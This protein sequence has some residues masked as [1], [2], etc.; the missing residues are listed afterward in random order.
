MAAMPPVKCYLPD[1]LCTKFG[2][3]AGY[4]ILKVNSGDTVE[5]VIELVLKKLQQR[6]TTH[7]TLRPKFY[8]LAQMNEAQN[9]NVTLADFETMQELASTKSRDGF[10]KLALISTAGHRKTTVVIPNE[11]TMESDAPPPPPLDEEDDAMSMDKFKDLTVETPK[12]PTEQTNTKPAR[13]ASVEQAIEGERTCGMCTRAIP[14]GEYMEIGT[15]AYHVECVACKVC[16]A[17]LTKQGIHLDKV[18]SELLCETHFLDK[19]GDRCA[20]CTEVIIGGVL[21][22]LDGLWHPNCF[23]CAHCLKPLSGG[24]NYFLENE[25][26][27]CRRDYEELFAVRCHHCKLVC[28][29]QYVVMVNTNYKLHPQCLVC[30]TCKQPLDRM[31]FYSD[32][33]SDR[34]YC[35]EHYELNATKCSHCR[36]FINDTVVNYHDGQYHDH[37]FRSLKSGGKELQS[38]KQPSRNAMLDDSEDDEEEDKLE[39]IK[40]AKSRVSAA[41]VKKVV[42]SS[43][44]DLSDHDHDHDDNEDTRKIAASRLPTDKNSFPSATPQRSRSSDGDPPPPPPP[45]SEE[46]NNQEEEEE[47]QEP[48]TPK[49]RDPGS[50]FFSLKADKDI[51]DKTRNSHVS[52]ASAGSE[53]LRKGSFRAGGLLSGLFSSKGGQHKREHSGANLA[54]SGSGWWGSKSGSMSLAAPAAP[55]EKHEKPEKE[56]KE[57]KKKKK[58]EKVDEDGRHV[59]YK[60]MVD[61]QALIPFL[62]QGIAKVS[63]VPDLADIN[64]T[65]ND[66]LSLEKQLGKV[67]TQF[68]AETLAKTDV[69]WRRRDELQR[70]LESKKKDSGKFGAQDQSH[71]WLDFRKKDLYILSHNET[72]FNFMDYAGKTFANIRNKYGISHE[73]WVESVI[74][75]GITGGKLGVG[76]SGMLFYFS[77]DRRYVLKTITRGELKFFRKILRGYYDHVA[78]N[79]H[80]LLP[81]FFGMYKIQ[82]NEQ[83]PVRIIVMNNLFLTPLS[84]PEK[85][86]L[87]GSTRNRKVEKG[88]EK[89]AGGVL[90]DL[91]FEGKIDI[92]PETKKALCLQ[93]KLDTKWLMDCNIMDQSLLLGVHHCEEM[94]YQKDVLAVA[95]RNLT[96]ALVPCH[97]G[98]S[99]LVSCFQALKGGV[100]GF[101]KTDKKPPRIYFCGIIDILQEFAGTKRIESAY[102]GLRYNKKAISAVSSKLYGERFLEYMESIIV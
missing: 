1:D 47:E 67:P 95:P 20:A 86:D 100:P 43:S 52:V 54:S 2:I 85:Y 34:I 59:K 29:G 26:I 27:Y 58:K 79:P 57:K 50:S 96:G 94:I 19:Y 75:N 91:N 3:R 68:T 102:K 99:N 97:S 77:K 71:G 62:L 30:Y 38:A 51:D 14:T 23:T 28:E 60:D 55:P 31:K 32:N 66:I 40:P 13:R 74:T 22:A 9:A 69:I 73:N 98:G 15:N 35:K 56:H 12:G 17:D 18:S 87:K 93:M 89:E 42:E 78:H 41:S 44:E 11:D 25:N 5:Q 63:D 7:E 101:G 61:G 21:Q 48:H 80:T 90:K 53:K 84:I 64:V 24:E 39:S 33:S 49:H 16:Q 36:Q 88:E 4:I 82:I 83:K 37:C 81:R 70:E 6:I 10:L 65:V 92:G 76:K 46:E 72:E 8:R 45:D